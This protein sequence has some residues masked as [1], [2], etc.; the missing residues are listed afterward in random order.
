MGMGI[1]AKLQLPLLVLLLAL[2]GGSHFIAFPVLRADLLDERLEAEQRTL[3]LLALAIVPDVLAGD[4]A[5]IHR[6]IDDIRARHP[7]WRSLTL[8]SP[9]GDRLYPLQA[10]VQPPGLMTLTAEAGG[11]GRLTLG[12][13]VEPLIDPSLDILRHLEEMAVGLMVAGWILVAWMQRRWIV[14]PLLRVAEASRQLSRGSY[15]VAL[16]AP[17]ADEVGS[18]ILAFDS[19]R[20]AVA[21]REQALLDGERHLQV[22]SDNSAEAVLSLGRDGS[23]RSVNRAAQSMFRCEAEILTGLKVGDF[24]PALALFAFPIGH[25]SDEETEAFAMDG[26]RFPVM[27]TAREARLGDDTIVVATIVDLTQAKQSEQRLKDSEGRF[28]DLAVSASDWFWEADV[29]YRLTFVS[30]RIG[31]MV[32]LKPSA[33]L[34]FTYFDL[35]LSDFDPVLARAHGADIAA[36]RPFRD[37]IF[38][39]GP[40]GAKD[41]KIIRISGMPFFNES[42]NFIGYRGVGADITELRRRERAIELLTRRYQLILDTAGDGIVELSADGKAGYANRAA[43][44]MLHTSALAMVHVDFAALVGASAEDAAVIA[45]ACTQGVAHRVNDSV[46]RRGDDGSALP[47]EFLVAPMMRNDETD[48]AVLVFRDI[49]MRKRFETVLSEQQ[50]ELERLVRARTAE[51]SQEIATRTETEAALLASRRYLKGI[52]DSLF[53]GVLVVDA[54]HRITFANP[55]AR[56]ILDLG[57]GEME[58]YRL[59][60]FLRVEGG[61]ENGCPWRQSAADGRVVRNDDSVFV[62]G[63]RRLAVAFACSPLR[64]DGGRG[65]GLC[66]AI[67]SFRDIEALKEA[68]REAMQASRLAS[69]G[70]LAAGIAHEINTPIQYIGDNLGFIKSALADILPLME[71]RKAEQPG[72]DFLAAELP[73]AVEQ[74][75]DGVAQVARIVRSMK[76]F[77][78]PGNSQKAAVD[79]NRALD[80]TLTVSRSTWKHVA[81]VHTEFAADL[82]QVTCLPGEMNQVFLNLIVN[83]AHAIEESGKPLPGQ[84]RVATRVVGDWVEIEVGDSGTGVPAEIRERIFDPFF[85]T[86]AVGKGTGQGLSICYDVV[87]AKHGGQIAVGGRP[88]CRCMSRRRRPPTCK[89]RYR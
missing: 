10:D 76:E 6:S 79:I 81:A 3:D 51:L 31:E 5:K 15:D 4:L 57:E 47:V 52:T 59:D 43:A 11:A 67:M 69:V 60:D 22:V 32:G 50:V 68:Q 21:E 20:R 40:E 83:A 23:I 39:V 73:D 63:G 75:L 34:G 53:E 65:D 45:A 87:V 86:K 26:R 82:P 41:G 84:I 28:R 70:Q 42:G 88:A 16:P 56:R 19:M 62:V 18:L 58:G 25:M 12:V 17:S 48:G 89:G 27:V 2:L 74:S 35:G 54:R 24:I 49:T 78:H 30:D 71:A 37:L 80:S 33:V 38:G 77:S 55:S 36:H 8:T 44:E 72:L 85:T 61:A 29:D 9:G 1:R 46:F 7:W 13:Q 64:D 14:Q 66:G